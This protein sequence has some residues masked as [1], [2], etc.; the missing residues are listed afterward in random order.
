MNTIYVCIAAYQFLSWC[1]IAISIKT[2]PTDTELWGE[3]IS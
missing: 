2:A 1:W 3:E